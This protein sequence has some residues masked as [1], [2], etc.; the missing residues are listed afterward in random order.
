MPAY[1]YIPEN[2]TAFSRWDSQGMNPLGGSARAEPSQVV[3]Y[4]PRKIPLS[5]DYFQFFDVGVD[6]Y[7]LAVGKFTADDTLADLG[8]DGALKIPLDRPRT[9]CR[10]VRLIGDQALGGVRHV[11]RDTPVV[12]PLL[13][14]RKTQVDDLDDIGFSE[15][16]EQHGVI[17]TVEKLRP[18][19]E[20]EVSED[21]LAH[22]VFDIALLVYAGEQ[23]LAADVARHDDDGVFEV[24]DTPLA[25]RQTPVVEEL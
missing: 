1:I 12:K 4:A 24:D 15:R 6:F 9:I 2:A 23:I 16:P 7:G 20:M 13:Y 3:Q 21:M 14:L 19:V 17:N 8:L 11:H 25:V 18:E 5:H 22:A 10:R